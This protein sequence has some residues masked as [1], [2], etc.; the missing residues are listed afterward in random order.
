MSFEQFFRKFYARCSNAPS[1]HHGRRPRKI[2]PRERPIHWTTVTAKLLH[3]FEPS[4][5]K[6]NIK[7]LKNFSL[8]QKWKN[9]TIPE[10]LLFDFWL[11]RESALGGVSIV[12]AWN[13]CINYLHQYV[14]PINIR[15]YK[16]TVNVLDQFF[17]TCKNR[18]S[19]RGR[20]SVFK[21]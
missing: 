17:I 14:V 12:L 21:E 3:S 9:S 10:F 20:K 5:E 16:N 11:S 7:T 8:T 18:L 4:L 2:R 13:Q 19:E 1:G 15:Y 6:L